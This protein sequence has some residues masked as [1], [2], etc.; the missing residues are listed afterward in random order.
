MHSR[1]FSG[2]LV[3][4]QLDGLP[5][6]SAFRTSEAP[7]FAIFASLPKAC[8]FAVSP[9]VVELELAGSRRTSFLP[10]GDA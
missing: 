9:S 10:Q 5:S 2:A 7:N 3:H 1:A 4:S 8:C 6:K